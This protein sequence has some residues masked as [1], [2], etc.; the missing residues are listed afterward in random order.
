[1]RY[2]ATTHSKTQENKATWKWESSWDGLI[3]S[4]ATEC[5]RFRDSAIFLSVVRMDLMIS[6][7]SPA[8]PVSASVSSPDR[9]RN[10]ARSARRRWRLP[11]LLRPPLPMLGR[12]LGRFEASGPLIKPAS[13]AESGW[14]R[15]RLPRDVLEAGFLS[16][17][18]SGREDRGWSQSISDRRIPFSS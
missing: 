15:L 10:C 17:S 13:P 7:R 1:M 11:P 8:S 2:P 16:K 12:S 6:H 5:V 14:F 9:A 3:L 4:P 18:V